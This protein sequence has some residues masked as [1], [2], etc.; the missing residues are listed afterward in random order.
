MC[1]VGGLLYLY[2]DIFFV[3]NEGLGRGT[4]YYAKLL[5]LKLLMKLVVGKGIT[6]LQVYGDSNLI[7]N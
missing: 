1:G 5:A 7:I 2:D 6:M 3:F 4:N